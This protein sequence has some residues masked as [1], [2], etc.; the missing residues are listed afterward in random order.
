MR[1]GR[2]HGQ[3]LLEQCTFAGVSLKVQALSVPPEQENGGQDL[4]FKCNGCTTTS[5]T[6]A[7]EYA[8]GP[9]SPAVELGAGIH[10]SI[11]DHSFL[12]LSTATQYAS[13]S[14]R[15]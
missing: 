7:G 10:A 8:C 6:Q 1:C 12:F 9:T 2:G 4:S 11:F 5:T 15:S 14:P 13:A 3:V